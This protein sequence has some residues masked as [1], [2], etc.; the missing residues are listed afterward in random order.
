MSDR[1]NRNL[2]SKFGFT[3]A[4][5]HEESKV[6]QDNGVDF[7]YIE[8]DIKEE[9]KQNVTNQDDILNDMIDNTEE[10]AFDLK[11]EDIADAI[12]DDE[13]IINTSAPNKSNV[14]QEIDY[15]LSNMKKEEIIPESYA[16]LQ[17]KYKK[18]KE[19]SNGR[20]ND[21]LAKAKIEHI[22]K[23]R[24]KKIQERW[25]RAL[26]HFG[27][28]PDLYCTDKA[29]LMKIYPFSDFSFI[30]A[31]KGE[32]NKAK[33]AQIVLELCKFEVINDTYNVEC[34]VSFQ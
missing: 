24:E 18:L 4:K 29:K 31:K 5:S 30:R 11:E 33:M 2:E 14:K 16:E 28:E 21:Q 6:D 19:E 25:M 12:D 20:M 1:T 23:M 7:N 17:E 27:V 22:K 34:R 26:V 15:T 3:G 32:F 10:N 9:E 8:M 13:E